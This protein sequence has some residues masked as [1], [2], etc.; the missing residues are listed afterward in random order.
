MK[1]NLEQ[2]RAGQCR[3]GHDESRGEEIGWYIDR[4]GKERKVLIRT[5]LFLRLIKGCLNGIDSARIGHSV[6]H[7]DR[8]GGIHHPI[9][10][11]GLHLVHEASR[12]LPACVND[13]IID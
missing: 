11:Y 12:F 1:K 6:R 10:N 13:S 5:N 4:Q 8:V 3:L 7:T 2:V 9:V